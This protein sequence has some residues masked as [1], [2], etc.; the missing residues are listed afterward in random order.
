MDSTTGK[1]QKNATPSNSLS[2]ED[3][4]EEKR[5][6]EETQSE[7]QDRQQHDSHWNGARTGDQGDPRGRRQ[8]FENYT[9]ETTQAERVINKFGGAKRLLAALKA[10]GFPKNPA[11]VYRWLYPREKGGTGGIIPTKAWPDI[12][13]AARIEGIFLTAEDV[14]P[15]NTKTARRDRKSV[16]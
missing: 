8:R 1:L 5:E 16:V 7:T 12:L 4:F 11:T 2:Y 15:W 6:S 13:T 9:E 3:I 10:V 14:G